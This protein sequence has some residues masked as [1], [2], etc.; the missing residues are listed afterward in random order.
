MSG[1][2]FAVI[3]ILFLAIPQWIIVPHAYFAARG[4]PVLATTAMAAMTHF[5]RRAGWT[6]DR[7]APAPVRLTLLAAIALQFLMQTVM[8]EQWSAYRRDLAQLVATRSGI[9][10]WTRAA[11]ALNPNLT[12]FRRH[13]VWSWSVQP[14]SIVLAPQDQVRAIVDVRPGIRWQPYV[15]DD[16]ATLPLCAKGLDWVP[17]LKAIG[18]TPEAA[19]ARCASRR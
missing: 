15:S 3:A 5:F 4:Y 10:E 16:P 19:L 7:I 13:L 18:V 11:D 2:I 12:P 14:L 17:F 8:T 6:V 1:L 9:I